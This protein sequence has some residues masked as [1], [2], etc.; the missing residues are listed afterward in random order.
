MRSLDPL[1]LYYGCG[2]AHFLQAL[3]AEGFDAYGVEFDAPTPAAAAVHAVFLVATVVDLDDA[4]PDQLFKEVHLVF[5]LEYLP[6]FA[7]A[8]AAWLMRLKPGGLSSVEGP[9]ETNPSSANFL[10]PPLLSR[11]FPGVP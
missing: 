8:L 7:A 3:K 4:C 10:A 11:C 2:V 6:H 5:V 1:L 9:P